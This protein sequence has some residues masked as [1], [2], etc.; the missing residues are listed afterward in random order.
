MI[1]AGVLPAKLNTIIQPL[2]GVTRVGAVSAFKNVYCIA[3][4]ALVNSC[5]PVVAERYMCSLS[6]DWNLYA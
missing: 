2:M 3:L 6:N 4:A 1:H 5:K